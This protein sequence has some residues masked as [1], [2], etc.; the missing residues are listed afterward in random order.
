VDI[1]RC[2]YKPT[3][4]T[5]G[6]HLVAYATGGYYFSWGKNTS[7]VCLCAFHGDSARDNGGGSSSSHCF[8]G[9]N[10]KKKTEFIINHNLSMENSVQ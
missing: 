10:M 3:N 8:E 5:W 2:G 1:Y 4:I 9:S 6:P 7:I